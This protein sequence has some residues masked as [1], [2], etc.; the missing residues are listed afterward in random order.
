M[1]HWITSAAIILVA[2]T[3]LTGCETISEDACLAGS[4]EDIGFKDGEAGRSRT[5]LADIAETCAEYGV[6]PDRVL[7]LSGFEL[8]VERYCS[9]RNGFEAGR[10]GS[11]PNAECE[12][13]GFATY[14]DAYDD[15]LA[16]HRIQNERDDLVHQWED[17]RDALINVTTRLEATDLPDSERRRLDKKAARLAN[18]MDDLR[19]DI[20]ALERLHDIPR[21]SPPDS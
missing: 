7:Y 4:W 5:R 8:G 16:V 3:G 14:L 15:G 10:N 12:A 20:R 21:W 6:T 19:I 13:G 18:R 9:P 2:G 1:K 17:D 11:A